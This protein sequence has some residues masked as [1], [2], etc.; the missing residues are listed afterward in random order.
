MAIESCKQHRETLLTSVV[1]KSIE[2][3]AQGK[4]HFETYI[5]AVPLSVLIHE[6]DLSESPDDYERL[7]AERI[8]VAL[9]VQLKAITA[10]I[11]QTYERR[12]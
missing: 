3:F 10:H 7:I 5:H 9:E 2:A 1:K 6:Y 8:R 12:M 11:E 4:P